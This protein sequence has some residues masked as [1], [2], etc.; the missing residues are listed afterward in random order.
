M[1]NSTDTTWNR[2]SDLPNCSADREGKSSSFVAVHVVARLPCSAVTLSPVSLF[3]DG[4][5]SPLTCTGRYMSL[6][7]FVNACISVPLVV[8]FSRFTCR[9][10][11][12][13]VL[14][15]FGDRRCVHT[16]W[17]GISRPWPLS[18]RFH[19]YPSPFSHLYQVRTR[20]SVAQS[21]CHLLCGPAK[22]VLYHVTCA[23]TYS[24]LFTQRSGR[25]ILQ[26]SDATG[27]F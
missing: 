11:D 2:T 18:G 7:V 23:S 19:C 5:L 9:V 16:E 26:L 8:W 14:L 1:K 21:Q 25:D 3:K 6:V 20:W 4:T 22:K 24:Q 17:Y 12:L 15:P 13:S 27:C 10:V